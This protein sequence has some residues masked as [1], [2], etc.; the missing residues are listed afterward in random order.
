MPRASYLQRY[1][2]SHQLLSQCFSKVSLAVFSLCCSHAAILILFSFVVL[3]LLYF[4]SHGLSPAL[5]VWDLSLPGWSLKRQFSPSLFLSLCF[6]LTPKVD[7]LGLMCAI[8]HRPTVL[9]T[10]RACKHHTLWNTSCDWGA[11]MTKSGGSCV[12]KTT[13]KAKS[14]YQDQQSHSLVGENKSANTSCM[15]TLS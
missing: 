5:R 1:N 11:T 3:M 14:S 4:C 9:K 6:S 12:N 7:L 10:H 13:R 15:H 8:S 2:P